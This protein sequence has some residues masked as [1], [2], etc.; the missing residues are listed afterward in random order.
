[1]VARQAGSETR[2]QLVRRHLLGVPGDGFEGEIVV[3]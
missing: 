1:M 3:S 2:E